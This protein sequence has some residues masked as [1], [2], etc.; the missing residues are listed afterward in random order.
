MKKI[1][2]ILLVTIIGCV[3]VWANDPAL[4]I[5]FEGNSPH[6]EA[7]A[8]FELISSEGARVLVNVYDPGLL[9]APVTSK[10]ILLTT[11]PMKDDFSVGFPGKQLMAE[12]GEI[13]V[14]GVTVR[15]ISSA[16]R[17]N[18]K[19][20][21]KGGT[22]TIYLIEIV[23]LR[24]ADFGG[25][26]QDQLSADQLGALG[27]VDIALSPLFN[28]DNLTNIDNLRGFNLM[29]Q[30][31]PKI[32]IPTSMDLDTA[33]FAVEKWSGAYWDGP[34]FKVGKGKLP[35]KTQVLFMGPKAKLFGK[36]CKIPLAKG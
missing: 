3:A 11:Q 18:E 24:V 2:L 4:S 7:L 6:D 13:K 29:D 30:V 35:I 23:G 16:H 34:E 31:K 10:D 20:Q 12:V 33:K 17:Y 28:L 9:S 27:P 5:R 19:P 36:A 15:G 32:L 26:G 1:F 25:I 8:Q 22:N 21:D 14:E